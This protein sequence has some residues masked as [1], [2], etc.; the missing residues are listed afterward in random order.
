M[1]P[2]GDT[3]FDPHRSFQFMTTAAKQPSIP[4]RT[5]LDAREGCEASVFTCI[6]IKQS[7][8]H[9]QHRHLGGC[10]LFLSLQGRHR[11][12]RVQSYRQQELCLTETNSK[13]PPYPHQMFLCSLQLFHHLDGFNWLTSAKRMLW[14]SS[15]SPSFE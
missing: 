12:G 13:E 2:D 14:S 8:S 15:S 7:N 5:A 1:K 4:V 10:F 11:C 3:A 6:V 9:Q